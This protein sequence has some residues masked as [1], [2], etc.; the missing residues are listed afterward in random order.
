MN[1]VS[2]DKDLKDIITYGFGTLVGYSI[3]IGAMYIFIKDKHLLFIY[4]LFI[5]IIIWLS[6]IQIK[7]SKIKKGGR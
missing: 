5:S 3:I 4:T 2:M 7:I 6:Y 1:I